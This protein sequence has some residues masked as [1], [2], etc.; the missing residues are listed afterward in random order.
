MMLKP[1]DVYVALKIVAA[2]SRRAP[3]AQLSLDLG[4]SASE[5]HASI[6][7]CQSARL[8][9][10]PELDNRPNLVALEEFLVHGLKY[11]FPAER[12]QFTRGMPTSYA[13]PPLRDVIAQ[14]ND[15]I[16]VWPLPDGKARGVA[17]EPLYKT[18]P[19]ASQRDSVLY[20]YLALTDALRDGR[21]RERKYAEQELHRRLRNLDGKSKS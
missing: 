11:A 9:Q 5:V 17:L 6:K 1:Q 16:P 2:N 10:G 15:P 3:Y 4:M 21:S 8:L 20:E 12:G 19:H 14:G 18:A 7:R 13:A